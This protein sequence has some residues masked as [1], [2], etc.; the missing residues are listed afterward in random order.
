[1]SY[2]SSGYHVAFFS[3]V[4]KLPYERKFQVQVQTA[5]MFAFLKMVS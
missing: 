3:T 2:I 5:A 1:M 4:Q